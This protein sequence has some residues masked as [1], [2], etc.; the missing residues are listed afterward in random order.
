MHNDFFRSED[1]IS[2]KDHL[3]M[4]HYVKKCIVS[5]MI[6]ACD[7]HFKDYT[8]CCR[9]FCNLDLGACRHGKIAI[10]GVHMH[11]T[12]VASIRLC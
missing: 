12:N 11:K 1:G 3:T 4:C 2:G 10:V 6:S 8:A 5:G 7:W 9:L